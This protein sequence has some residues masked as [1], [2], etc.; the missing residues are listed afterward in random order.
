MGKGA[1]GPA[2]G[3]AGAGVCAST[4]TQLATRKTAE[5][6]TLVIIAMISSPPLIG[7]DCR[8]RMGGKEQA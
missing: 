2:F 5:Q 8:P 1:P 7:L 4:D 3:V 6:N